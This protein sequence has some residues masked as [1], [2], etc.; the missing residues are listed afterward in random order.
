[1]KFHPRFLS[2]NYRLLP[3]GSEGL[4]RSL[5]WQASC[6]W[7]LALYRRLSRYIW[8]WFLLFLSAIIAPCMKIFFFNFSP[9]SYSKQERIGKST[10]F[11]HIYTIIS[12]FFSRL[13]IPRPTKWFTFFPTWFQLRLDFIP[14][15]DGVDAAKSKRIMYA[16]RCFFY[17]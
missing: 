9:Y 2:L 12:L 15:A 8:C 14:S 5:C 16:S 3:F 11:F 13:I 17:F 10:L 4:M 7:I 6:K 1:M